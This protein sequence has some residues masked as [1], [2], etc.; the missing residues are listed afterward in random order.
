MNY[1]K[2]DRGGGYFKVEDSNM[3]TNAIANLANPPKMIRYLS[4]ASE[5]Y[6][7]GC[8]TPVL[9]NCFSSLMLFQENLVEDANNFIPDISKVN[10]IGKAV[11][12]Y[13]GSD[14][15]R[16]TLNTAETKDLENGKRYVWDFGT[17]KGNGT[18]RSVA[19]SNGYR[20]Y[21]GF[22]NFLYTGTTVLEDS[23]FCQ[24]FLA[25]AG[26]NNIIDA[27]NTNVDKSPKFYYGA[28]A[29]LTSSAGFAVVGCYKENEILFFKTTNGSN[30]AIFEKAI[31]EYSQLTLSSGKSLKR[32]QVSKTTQC[33]LSTFFS[34]DNEYLYSFY[35]KTKNTFSVVKIDTKT[36]DVV[37][38]EYITI[39]DIDFLGAGPLKG[40][41]H[42]GYYYILKPRSAGNE[43][44]QGIYKINVNDTSDYS[45]ITANSIFK[46][47]EDT[48]TEFYNYAFSVMEG[49]LLLIPLWQDNSSYSPALKKCLPQYAFVI[50]TSEPYPI[51]WK[52]NYYANS[53]GNYYAS[54]CKMLPS[55][56]IKKPFV[57]ATESYQYI[58]NTTNTNN[59]KLGFNTMFLSTINNL[60]TPV[61]KNETQTMK[62]T[63]EITEI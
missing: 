60:S 32:E 6:M 48:T 28:P 40:I 37:Q 29:F 9:D 58:G 53:T 46:Q 42:E 20:G 18:I 30:L 45:Y 2:H 56:G 55:P 44:I 39:Q 27:N 47:P 62:V 15:S 7:P 12:A 50:N 26:V 23:T 35:A 38:D 8:I 25:C 33:E 36:L 13:V 3:V 63:Y 51:T 4:G 61:V 17:D 14:P 21:H 52:H 10:S 19:L 5:I 59:V 34:A 49:A 16:G 1:L 11:N 41:I 24:I 43:A 31:V 57:F 22:R 54:N